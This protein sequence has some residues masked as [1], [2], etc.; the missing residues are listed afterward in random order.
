MRNLL[1][2]RVFSNTNIDKILWCVDLI[3]LHILVTLWNDAQNN[4]AYI[5]GKIL[6]FRAKNGITNNV[7]VKSY[8]ANIIL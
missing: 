8:D 6:M 3:E 4:F 7:S 1:H 5:F 2:E